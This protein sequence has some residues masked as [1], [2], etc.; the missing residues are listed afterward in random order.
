MK[1]LKTRKFLAAALALLFATASVFAED[2]EPPLAPPATR[3]ETP[4]LLRFMRAAAGKFVQDLKPP[5]PVKGTLIL[6][7]ALYQGWN[8]SVLQY[9]PERQVYRFGDEITALVDFELYRSCRSAGS[10]VGQNAFGAKARVIRHSCELAFLESTEY[11]SVRLEGEIPLTREQ[12]RAVQKAGA[13][14]EVEFALAAD[15][16]NEAVSRD[17]SV[18]TPTVQSPEEFRG[19]K[20]TIH[21]VV[22]EVRMLLPGGQVQTIYKRSRT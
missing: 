19:P 15:A 7:R 17:E 11:G 18:T 12:F 3:M 9:D 6:V 2:Q 21:G 1:P 14:L 22:H 10:Y 20:W 16:A 13:P 8:F 4:A 5:G